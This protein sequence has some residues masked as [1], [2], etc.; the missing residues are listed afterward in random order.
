MTTEVTVNATKVGLAQIALCLLANAIQYVK[1]VAWGLDMS[2]VSPVETTPIEIVQDIV[3][4]MISGSWMTA[5]FG[6]GSVIQSETGVP[7][8]EIQ[9]A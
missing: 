6:Q 1:K 4:V 9:I 5:V 2:P 3:F 8:H 7:D